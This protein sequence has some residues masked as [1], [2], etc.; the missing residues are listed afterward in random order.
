MIKTKGVQ[1]GYRYP[2]TQVKLDKI[3][4][5]IRKYLQVQQTVPSQADIANF[6]E[7]EFGKKHSQCDVRHYLKLLAS[8]GLIVFKP[9]RRPAYKLM[10]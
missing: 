9:R 10:K 6:L 5:F 2:K 4:V 3:I 7:H 8:D 1:K